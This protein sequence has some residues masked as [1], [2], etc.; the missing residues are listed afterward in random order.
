MSDAT[1]LWYVRLP[2][3]RVFR[4]AGVASVRQH[5]QT[6]RIPPGSLVRRKDEDAWRPVEQTR[7]FADV[8]EGRSANGVPAAEAGTIASR[9]DPG[10]LQLVGVRGLVEDLLAA[11]DST[12]ARRKLTVTALIGLVVGVLLA[13]SQVTPPLSKATTTVL[14]AALGLVGA[15]VGLLT[16]LLAQMT[17]TELSQMRP[18]RWR[19]ALEGVAGQFLRV[20]VLYALVGGVLGSLIAVLR[21][22]PGL[23]RSLDGDGW[24]A[25][26]EWA[27]HATAVLALVVEVVLWPL[28]VL[29]LLLGVLTVVERCP[30]WSALLQWL[31]L[32]RRHFGRLL[33]AEALALGMG[34]AVV[35][36]LALPVAAVCSFQ[37]EDELKT[38]VQLTRLM[39]GGLVGT[40]LLA[41]LTV[42]NVFVYLK[43]RYELGGR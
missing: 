11:L 28:V 4:A 39:L 34:L 41:Y 5:V 8:A 23:V 35:I 1:E 7:E 18:A 12:L 37:P 33:L 24:E 20:G 13:L 38:T 27:A 15:A 32:L 9:L 29:M 2:D 31:G 6:G 42:A 25:V 10:Q 17:F 26:H 19:D 14:G 16:V 40:L 30:V 21:W 43:V 3:G 22:L 36:P